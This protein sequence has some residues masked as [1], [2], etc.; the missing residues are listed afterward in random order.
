M[1]KKKTRVVI[2]M[3]GALVYD[4]QA[5]GPVE[6]LVIDE[7]VECSELEDLTEMKKPDK[8][9]FTSY[10]RGPFFAAEQT[11]DWYFK[12]YEKLL[13]EGKAFTRKGGG[14]YGAK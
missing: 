11:A 3:Q 6:Y 4:V 2:F 7:D 8:S 9:V 13:R 10:V 12:Q 5:N 1:A 14:K